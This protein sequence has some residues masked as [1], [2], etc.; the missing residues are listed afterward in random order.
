MEKMKIGV[1]TG[2]LFERMEIGEV[3]QL[4]SEAGFDCVDFNINNEYPYRSIVEG[5]PSGLFEKSDEEILEFYRPY[6]EAAEKHNIA[7]GQAHA[8]FP[9]YVEND[10]GNEYVLN[11]IRKS[12]MVCGYIGCR[13]LVVH[14]SFLAYDRML[15]A[16]EEWKLNIERYSALIED[17]RKHDV[18]ICLEN[19]FISRNRRIYGAICAD[20]SETNRYID[21]LNEIAGEKRFAFCLDTGHALLAGKELYRLITELGHRIETLHIHDNDGVQDSHLFP[22]MGIV[23]W[24]RFCEGLKDI[25]YRG[26]LSFETDGAMKAFD[27]ALAPEMLKL[28]SATGRLFAKKI[29]G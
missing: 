11:A 29:A 9:T 20:A 26:H 18:V 23:D 24:D 8:P 2:S 17:A 28:L 25:G 5:K 16:E 21:T 3:F 22:Y 27:P 13:F 14:P 10:L 4:I 15:T 6:K 1:Q 19:M 12:I 7:F